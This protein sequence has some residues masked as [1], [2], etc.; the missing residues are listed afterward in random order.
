MI[1]LEFKVLEENSQLR[2]NRSPIGLP[3]HISLLIII[4][5]FLDQN[6]FQLYTLLTTL[7]HASIVVN[8]SSRLV[9]WT[10]IVYNITLLHRVAI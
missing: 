2:R 3:C 7:G 8:A 4:L 10:S 1:M 5:L 6:T 9:Q